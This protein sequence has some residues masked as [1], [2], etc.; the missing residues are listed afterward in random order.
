MKNGLKI[1]FFLSFNLVFHSL[2]A[3]WQLALINDT[4]GFTYVRSG[5]G[6]TFTTVATIQKDDLFYCESSASDWWKVT[7]RKNVEGFV[8]KSRI[9]IVKDMPIG[10]K[11]KLI[12][13]VFKTQEL[14]G[15][16]YM[17]GRIGGIQM[18][19]HNDD[20]FV[21]M[22]E[23]FTTYFSKTGDTILLRQFFDSIW[24]YSGSADERPSY[25]VG[26][27]FICKTE[28]VTAVIKKLPTSQRE[29]IV[30]AVDWG[31]LNHFNLSQEEPPRD[32]RYLEYKKK[33]N[34]IA[35]N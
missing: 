8:H 31:L 22:L 6:T 23:I 14:L 5:K 33:L 35:I 11:K 4:D 27:I 7:T 26:E 21:P 18:M 25:T 3:E 17:A 9:Q 15:D 34:Q 30:S 10:T 2:K 19:E 13:T 20:K 12:L 16:Q 1:L 32:K 24:A 29:H 28:L